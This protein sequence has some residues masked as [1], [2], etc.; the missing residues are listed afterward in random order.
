M[1]VNNREFHRKYQS[2]EEY[3]A[4]IVLRG[5]EV[6]SVKAGN[7]RLDNAYVKIF[8]DG[9]WL[10]NADV[11]KYRFSRSDEYDP[12]RKR[13]LL[14]N[15]KEIERLQTKVQS[16]IERNA[17]ARVTRERPPSK[18]PA[19]HDATSAASCFDRPILPR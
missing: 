13:K 19:R 9:V 16:T 18:L 12:L 15:K 6:K 10:I 5:G 17:P 3:E 8:E 4:G 2:L 14:L 7:I 1:L 11:P